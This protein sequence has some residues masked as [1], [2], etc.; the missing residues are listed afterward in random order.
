M[1]LGLTLLKKAF[2]YSAASGYPSK[3]TRV[4]G[5]H[6]K[7]VIEVRVSK[8]TPRTASMLHLCEEMWVFGS[9]WPLEEIGWGSGSL[10]I[11]L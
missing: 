8:V 10:M 11:L 4:P 6:L 9:D 5:S 2:G 3:L 1:E 7:T